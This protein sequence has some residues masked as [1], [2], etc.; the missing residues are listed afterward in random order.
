MSQ[1]LLDDRADPVLTWRTGVL[2]FYSPQFVAALED[3]YCRSDVKM[4]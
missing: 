2:H 3:I 4:S 1:E